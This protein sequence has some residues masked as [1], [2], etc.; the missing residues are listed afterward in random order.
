MKTSGRIAVLGA[1]LVVPAVLAAQQ[2]PAQRQ[3]P[4][5]TA[6][7]RD[8]I[9]IMLAHKSDLDLKADQVSKL[10]AIQKKLDNAATPLRK[11]LEAFRA[12]RSQRQAGAFLDMTEAQRRQFIADRQKMRDAGM[13]LRELNRAAGAQAHAVLTTDQQTRLHRMMA[14]RWGRGMR[15][16]RGMWMHRGMRPGAWQGRG[17]R[18]GPPNGGGWG[19]GMGPGFGPPGN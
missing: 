17:M 11:Q 14:R 3:A 9:A 19:P 7:P 1:L 13:E 18:N 8:P 16:E 5:D 15:G 4:Q 12:N 6:R 10:E 2:P